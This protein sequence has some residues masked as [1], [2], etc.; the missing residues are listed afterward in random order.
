M[1]AVAS[2]AKW[3]SRGVSR[4]GSV[5][6]WYPASADDLSKPKGQGKSMFSVMVLA[7]RSEIAEDCSSGATYIEM[8]SRAL[9][10]FW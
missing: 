4:K 5:R 2:K 6:Q 3:C 9:L 1:E 8:D 10:G 7:D